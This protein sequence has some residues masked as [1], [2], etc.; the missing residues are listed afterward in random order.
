[1]FC[2]TSEKEGEVE[3]SDSLLTALRRYFCCGS[4][5]PVFAVRVSMTFYLR[6]VHINYLSSVWVAD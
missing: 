5:L 2:H 1:M 6:C 4:L 3:S